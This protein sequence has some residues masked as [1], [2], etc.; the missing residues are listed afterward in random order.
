MTTVV[1]TLLRCADSGCITSATAGAAREG[2]QA[3]ESH[4]I[5]V[6]LLAL[7]TSLLG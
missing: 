1:H 2:G 4:S 3:M 7:L 6:V 5:I